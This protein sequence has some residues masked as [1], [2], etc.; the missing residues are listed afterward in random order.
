MQVFYSYWPVAAFLFCMYII[1]ILAFYQLH[2]E[3]KGQ[4]YV[5]IDYLNIPL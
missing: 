2:I 5:E 4:I 1:A 3:R